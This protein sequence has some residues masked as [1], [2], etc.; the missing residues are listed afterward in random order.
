MDIYATIAECIGFEWDDANFFKNWEKHKVTAPECEQIF[1]NQPLIAAKDEKHSR[2]E[3]R[4]YALGHTQFGRH[5]F[6]VFTIRK[7][8][9]RVISARDMSRKERKVYERS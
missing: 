4:Y 7:D 1:F 3:S 9:I 5:L 6:V 2:K 8:R